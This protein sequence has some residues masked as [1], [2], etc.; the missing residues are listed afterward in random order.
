MKLKIYS[1]YNSP[2]EKNSTAKSRIEPRASWTVSNDV[3]TK[4]NERTKITLS[5][6]KGILRLSQDL[7]MIVEIT[8]R[9]SW[10]SLSSFN[11]Q[12]A[13]HLNRQQC[14]RREQHLQPNAVSHRTWSLVQPCHCVRVRTIRHDWHKN[15]S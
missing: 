1:S 7:W 2:V 9:S 13:T 8:M 6:G 3:T 11:Q 15:Q 5:L 4:P 14:S 10:F 12:S